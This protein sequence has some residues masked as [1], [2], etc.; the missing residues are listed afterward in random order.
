MEVLQTSPLGH[1]GTAPLTQLPRSAAN[2]I[3]RVEYSQYSGFRVRSEVPRGICLS[4]ALLSA[5]SASAVKYL[6]LVLCDARAAELSLFPQTFHPLS[7][8]IAPLL[9]RDPNFA[10]EN[11]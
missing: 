10:E 4:L 1:L 5:L 8:T 7:V 6:W 11:F 9:I 3:Y 2:K